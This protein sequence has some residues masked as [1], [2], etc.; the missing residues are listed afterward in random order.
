MVLKLFLISLILIAIKT[1]LI[2]CI[3]CYKCTSTA[4]DTSCLDPFNPGLVSSNLYEE[5]CKTGIQD[6]V[7]LFP[8][9]YCLKVS[10]YKAGTNEQIVIR[11]C[12]VNKL[13]DSDSSHSSFTLKLEDNQEV[14]VVSGL[15][16]SCKDDGCNKANRNA[17][18]FKKKTNSI[19]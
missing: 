2:N 13:L 17:L 14:K 9:R 16:A 11:T 4:N 5:E 15:I 7:G 18:L 8:A 6:R 10:G 3:G 19:P 12:T 1:N